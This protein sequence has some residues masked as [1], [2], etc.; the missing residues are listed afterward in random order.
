MHKLSENYKAVSL[1]VAQTATATATGT[2]VD[3]STYG[4]D[5]LFIL[6]VGAVSGT[7]PTLDVVIQSSSTVGGTYSTELTFGQVTASTKFACGGLNI[8]GNNSGAIAR[9]FIRALATIAGTTPSFAF[10]VTMLIR[11]SLGSA[12]LNSVTPA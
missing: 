12:S 4:D 3:V 7:S 8:E 2:G 6:N 1:L 10:S 11:A 9:K 5:A